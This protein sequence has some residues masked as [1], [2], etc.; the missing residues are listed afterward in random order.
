VHAGDTLILEEWNQETQGYT[1]RKVE[2][3]VTVVDEVAE[4]PTG[5]VQEATEHGSLTVH[6]E[7]KSQSTLSRANISKKAGKNG[8]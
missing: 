2:T 3:V 6:F 1:G 5:S 8:R 4:T 7:L